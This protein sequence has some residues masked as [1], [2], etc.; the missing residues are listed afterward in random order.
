MILM[1]ELLNT[2]NSAECEGIIRKPPRFGK[3]SNI[4][5]LQSMEQMHP[6]FAQLQR[7]S[8]RLLKL[9]TYFTNVQAEGV[10]EGGPKNSDGG[11]QAGK[12]PVEIL[13]KIFSILHPKNEQ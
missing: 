8:D 10:E 12:V 5:F 4:G 11:Q 9:K 1:C 13:L 7:R 6:C 3:R 2:A